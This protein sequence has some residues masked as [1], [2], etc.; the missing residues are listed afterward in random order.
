MHRVAIRLYAEH[1]MM[2]VIRREESKDP[3]AVHQLNLAAFDDGPEATVVAKL[4]L[5]C[6]DYHSSMS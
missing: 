4:R 3:D 2:I 6:E 1:L 5:S